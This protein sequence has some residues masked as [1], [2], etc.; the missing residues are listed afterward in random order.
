MR[1]QV[2]CFFPMLC[3]LRQERHK[4]LGCACLV[5]AASKHNVGAF[6][7]IEIP[8]PDFVTG[9]PGAGLTLEEVATKCQVKVHGGDSVWAATIWVW[10]R[11]QS[12]RYM[13]L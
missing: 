4:L 7:T 5:V 2:T 3:K 9:S 13:R 10:N 8:R 1:Y 12:V 11:Y 6:A